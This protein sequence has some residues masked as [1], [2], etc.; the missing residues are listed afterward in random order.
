[1]VLKEKI[2]PKLAYGLQNRPFVFHI[3]TK[4]INLKF[5]FSQKLILCLDYQ[6]MLPCNTKRDFGFRNIIKLLI[7]THFLITNKICFICRAV[8]KKKLTV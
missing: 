7:L 8:L 1:M 2:I 4:I 6:F 3:G 5:K